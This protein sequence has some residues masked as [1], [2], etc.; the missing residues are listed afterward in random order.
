MSTA[1]AVGVITRYHHLVDFWWIGKLNHMK[2]PKPID[3]VEAMRDITAE[4]DFHHCKYK[5]KKSFTDL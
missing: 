3:W 1:A 2:P 4:L 5:F